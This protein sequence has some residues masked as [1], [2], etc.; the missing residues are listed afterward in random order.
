LWWWQ[1][2]I[3]QSSRRHTCGWFQSISI[4]S[5][6]C[7]LISLRWWRRFVIMVEEIKLSSGHTYSAGIFSLLATSN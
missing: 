6:C 4:G 7:C 3:V 1:P 5:R 2:W